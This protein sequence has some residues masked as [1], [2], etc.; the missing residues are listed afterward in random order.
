MFITAL[1]SDPALRVGACCFPQRLGKDPGALPDF[2]EGTSET[3]RPHRKDGALCQ[4]GFNNRR[5]SAAHI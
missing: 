1:P 5:M 4:T 3:R 2:R